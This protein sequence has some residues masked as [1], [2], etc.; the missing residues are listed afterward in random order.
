MNRHQ[1]HHG[2]WHQSP[3]ERP[4]ASASEIAGWVSGTIPA[5]LYAGP[6]TVTVDDD[7]ILVV[8]PVAA[9]EVPAGLDADGVTEARRAR[10][11]AFREETRGARIGVAQQAEV[12]FARTISWGATAGG[13]SERSPPSTHGSAPDW[14]C[15]SARYWTP[16]WTVAWP[17]TGPRPWPGA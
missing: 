16:W 12:R 4:G 6:P 2:H 10:V 3:A 1:S 5:D 15:P 11:R 9:P 13:T 14:R 17:P 8:G 7:E